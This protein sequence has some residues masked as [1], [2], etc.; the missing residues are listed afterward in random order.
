MSHETLTYDGLKKLLKTDCTVKIFETLESTNITAKNEAKNGAAEG[1]LIIARSQSGGRGRLGRSFYS[2][3]GTG[4]YLS[5]VLKPDILSEDIT[6]ITPI[7]AISVSK[8]IETVTKKSPLI[9]WVNDIFLNN[10]KVCGILSEAML[11]SEGSAEY[12]ILGIGI[13]LITPVDGY[14]DDIKDIA[15]S[16]YQKDETP[17][18]NSLIAAVVNN[19]FE[20]YKDL[21]SPALPNEYQ[22][23]MMLT[24]SNI[25]YIKNGVQESG[26][27]MGID[28]NFHLIVKK[29]NGDLAHLQS[30]EI[31]IG[32][33]ILC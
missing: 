10:K 18:I 15:G 16:V 33:K 23:R 8:A 14:P 25:N 22:N 4:I 28:K 19:F 6:L 29:E 21:N 11:N 26:V 13:N 5:I 32:S 24:G 30:G 17:N 9:K 12:V 7:A 2:P 20:M 3:K 1:T 27:V 31:T